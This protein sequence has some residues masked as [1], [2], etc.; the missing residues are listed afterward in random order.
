MGWNVQL[1]LELA[2]DIHVTI[3]AVIPSIYIKYIK[4]VVA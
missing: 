1:L 4:F 3:L 2:N